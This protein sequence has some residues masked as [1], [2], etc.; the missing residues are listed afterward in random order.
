MNAK[1]LRERVFELMLL[2]DST[3][4]LNASVGIQYQ[5]EELLDSLVSLTGLSREALDIAIQKQYIDW[6]SKRQSPSDEE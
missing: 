5:I 2:W 3:D 6:V 1:Q 4:D